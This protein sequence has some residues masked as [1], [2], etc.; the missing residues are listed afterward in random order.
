MARMVNQKLTPGGPRQETDRPPV[1]W[2]RVSCRM[3]RRDSRRRTL[4][5]WSGCSAWKTRANKQA[6]VLPAS[7]MHV[8]H[9][10]IAE[11]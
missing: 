3:L 10:L 11:C 6:A 8:F 2:L 9:R 5:N 1:K 4:S 7:D